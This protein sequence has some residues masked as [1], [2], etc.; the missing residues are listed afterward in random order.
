MCVR[1][2]RERKK[3]VSGCIGVIERVLQKS[4]IKLG[5]SKTLSAVLGY[6]LVGLLAEVDW[7]N[8]RL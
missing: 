3:E 4:S 1:R 8:G 6:F 7:D 2:G 5:A